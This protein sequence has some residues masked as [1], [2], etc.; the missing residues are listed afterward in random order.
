MG[1]IAASAC[2]GQ[3]R[4]SRSRCVG[5]NPA[6]SQRTSPRRLTGPQ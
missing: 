4:L 1:A 3:T 5:Q 2:E 6:V